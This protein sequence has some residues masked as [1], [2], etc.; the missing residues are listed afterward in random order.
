MKSE[1]LFKVADYEAAN[2]DVPT[3]L[4]ANPQLCDG[5][6]MTADDVEAFIKDSIATLR[7][8]ADKRSP[9]YSRVYANFQA[10][11]AALVTLGHIQEDEYNDLTDDT[12]LRF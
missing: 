12:N 10:D 5:D 11:M 9:H 7:I 3:E 2:R 4:A 8:L 6:L 1:L